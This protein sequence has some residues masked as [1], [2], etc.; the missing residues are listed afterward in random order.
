MPPRGQNIPVQVL[1]YFVMA[2]AI[3]VAFIIA[4]AVGGAGWIA[5][6]LVVLIVGAYAA[7]DRRRRPQESRA[8]KL[9][10]DPRA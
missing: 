7:Y 2:G 10:A 5:P 1:P 9:A 6:I 4:I 8:E 3:V